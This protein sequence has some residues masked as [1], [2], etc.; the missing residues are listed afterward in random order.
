MSLKKQRQQKRRK[1]LAEMLYRKLGN[2]FSDMQLSLL[3]TAYTMHNDGIICK[4][5]LE[6]CFVDIYNGL[7]DIDFGCS[8]KI[9]K[10]VESSMLA[11]EIQG[12]FDFFLFLRTF[13]NQHAFNN[14]IETLA[15]DLDFLQQMMKENKN[16]KS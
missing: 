16:Q 13:N 10:Q 7:E 12:R 1:V 11:L 4:P 15:K 3:Y 5:V 6:R 9:C 2:E 8:C 14:S